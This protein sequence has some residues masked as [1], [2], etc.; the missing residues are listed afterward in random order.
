MTGL[1]KLSTYSNN[2]D[3]GA[4]QPNEPTS[5]TCR[6]AIIMSVYIIVAVGQISFQ[7]MLYEP[8][9]KDTVREFIDLCSISNVSIDFSLCFILVSY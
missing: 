9:I 4:R 7:M 5:L 8:L 2:I 1:I 6:I 3:P